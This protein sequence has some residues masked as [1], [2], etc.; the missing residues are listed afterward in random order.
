MVLITGDFNARVGNMSDCIN[1]LDD[2]PKSEIRDDVKISHGDSLID[3]L[4]DTQT[5]IVNGRISPTANKF[6]CI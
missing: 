4:K 6:T 1:D 2:I 5:C 3:F